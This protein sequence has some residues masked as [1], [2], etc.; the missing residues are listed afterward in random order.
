MNSSNNIKE[1]NDFFQRLQQDSGDEF[2]QIAKRGWRENKAN[3]NLLEKSDQKFLKSRKV[4]LIYSVLF[5]AGILLT[6]FVLLPAKE[7]KRLSSKNDLK[8]DNSNNTQIALEE[9]IASI[10][11][12]SEI[13]SKKQIKTSSLKK[14]FQERKEI[15]DESS[16]QEE[17]TKLEIKKIGAFGDSKNQ[18]IERLKGAELYLYDLLC[19]DYTKYRKGKLFKDQKS[20]L[21][22]TAANQEKKGEE[23]TEENLETVSIDVPYVDYLDKSMYLFSKG[24]MKEALIRFVKII[25]TYPNDVNAN[26]YGGLCYYNIGQYQEAKK[27][28][29]QLQSAEFGNFEEEGDW[30]LAKTELALKNKEE[31][32]AILKKII[33]GKGFYAAQ[34]KS[35]LQ[36]LN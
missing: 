4:Y 30:Y 21:G 19:L 6:F 20:V 10:Q 35:E 22:G 14:D 23:S 13:S 16:V 32:K 36:K 9:K 33:D 31:A 15:K 1:R 5:L 28:F 34:A 25:E 24:E 11:A 2:D 7:Q 3:P 8:A 12:S 18:K 29:Q 26:F 17:T 27:C